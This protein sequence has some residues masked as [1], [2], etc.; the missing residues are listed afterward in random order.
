[1]IRIEYTKGQI[2]NRLE[3]VEDF[4]GSPREAVSCREENFKNIA[5]V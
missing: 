2:L 1:M 4:G 3:F 5:Y